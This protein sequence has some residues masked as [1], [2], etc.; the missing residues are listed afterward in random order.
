MLNAD[1]KEFEFASEFDELIV[2][3]AIAVP[4]GEPNG[5]VQIVHG[6]QEHKERYYPFMDYLAEEG[7]IT[8]IHDNRGHGK[9]ICSEDD[10]GFMFRN[11][12]EGFI[13]DI[14]QINRFIH[15][16]YPQLPVFITGYGT[17]ASGVVGFMKKNDNSANGI[18]L[19]GLPCYSSFSP[20]VRGIRSEISKKLGTRFRSEKLYDMIDDRFGKFFEQPDNSW[21]CS[22]PD[23]VESFN[24]DPLCN[25]K[26]TMN[27]YEEMLKLIKNADSPKNW[28]ISNPSLPIRLISGKD[29]PC[30]IS[31]KK[32]FKYIAKLEKIGYESIS[33]RIF[34][35]M[36]HDLLNEK[37]SINVWKD[38]AKSLFSWIDRFND[39]TEE[40]ETGTD[41]QQ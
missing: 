15:E 11:G 3:A 37:N 38:I 33:H 6:M 22:D 25:F 41:T 34:E 26:I 4:M 16:T 5:I 2:S 35:G 40:P 14:A 29:D 21:R 10:L 7:F 39:P 36:R 28:E 30:M 24:S 12:S 17:G 32:F 8:V 20:V 27:G 19:L 18:V 31:E 13:S 23:A 1:L 9:S